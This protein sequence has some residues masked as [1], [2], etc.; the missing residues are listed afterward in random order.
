MKAF[1]ALTVGLLG[2][3]CPLLLYA[4]TLKADFMCEI[5][6]TSQPGKTILREV[7]RRSDLRIFLSLLG[8][9]QGIS[10][11]VLAR[12]LWYP[13]VSDAAAVGQAHAGKTQSAPQKRLAA[14]AQSALPEASQPLLQ[15]EN[16]TAEPNL[17]IA[18][19]YTDGAIATSLPQPTPTTAASAF[20]TAPSP[21]FSSAGADGASTLSPPEPILSPQP[22]A[23][24]L[25]KIEALKR[26][27]MIGFIVQS[28]ELRHHILSAMTRCGK[29]TTVRAFLYGLWLVFGPNMYISIA[30]P[31]KDP[32]GWLG[33][34]TMPGIVGYSVE[35]MAPTYNKVKQAYE[36]MIWRIEHGLT[37]PVFVLLIDEYNGELKNAERNKIDGDFLF[38][39]DEI[40][41]KGLGV[42]IVLK[43]VAHSHLVTNIGFDSQSRYNFV[44]SGIGRRDAGYEMIYNILGDQY[45][46]PNKQARARMRIE[47]QKALALSEANGLPLMATTY[48]GGKVMQLPNLKWLDTV[49]IDRVL[50]LDSIYS[51]EA[52]Q[53]IRTTPESV[54]NG[55]TSAELRIAEPYLPNQ[56]NYAL[57]HGSSPDPKVDSVIQFNSIRPFAPPS[58]PDGM[59]ERL[60]ELTEFGLSYE[61]ALIALQ[62]I[63][64]TEPGILSRIS[65]LRQAGC[66]AQ[67]KLI[68]AIW[69]ARPGSNKSYEAAVPVYKAL[70]AKLDKTTSPAA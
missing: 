12:R 53:P 57:S 32:R 14:A 38:M 4:S 58:T 54:Q 5:D 69:N 27:S 61:Q 21:S 30:D 44:V 65:E 33:L 63:E 49:V 66:M 47:A 59:A 16:A 42:G 35:S 68:F 60:T 67:N 31:K 70:V 55:R 52:V 34:E 17:D 41:R 22:I 64:N 7:S 29:T 8:L 15:L 37:G 23:L 28:P 11:V 19:D 18:A 39:L 43:I 25:N 10:A 26:L 40:S 13:T 46:I 62:S 56:A 2:I 3:G 9:G 24:P 48:R 36:L 45:V 1:Q 51:S 20:V 6:T 50:P